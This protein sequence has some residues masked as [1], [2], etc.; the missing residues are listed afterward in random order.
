[1]KKATYKKIDEKIEKITIHHEETIDENGN[2]TPA[3]DEEIEKVIPIMGVVYE[4]MTQE[5]IDSLPKEE[6]YQPEPTQ[7]DIIEA[8]IMYTALMTD[9]LLEV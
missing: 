6:D 5:E 8:Q 7:L 9:T 3:W 4:E 2:I 1:M